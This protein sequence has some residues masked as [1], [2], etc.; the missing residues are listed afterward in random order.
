MKQYLPWYVSYGVTYNVCRTIYAVQCMSY[1]VRRKLTVKY[2]RTLHSDNDYTPYTVRRIIIIVY[3]QCIVYSA[4]SVVR[5]TVNNVHC[6]VV[7]PSYR[8]MAYTVWHI[9][10][11]TSY[12]VQRK[13][14]V[15]RFTLCS[16]II[17]GKLRCLGLP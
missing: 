1:N 14:Y 17:N 13:L 6:T 3:V 10:Y 8:Y 15:I 11:C 4:Y 16:V 5:C 2:K 12:N 9:L 7:M